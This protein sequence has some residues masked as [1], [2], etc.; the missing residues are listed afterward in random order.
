MLYRHFISKGPQDNKR[1][2]IKNKTIQDFFKFRKIPD[3]YNS[4]SSVYAVLVEL[5]SMYTEILQVIL[6]YS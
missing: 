2:Y 1:I 3:P 4:W 6:I 5:R